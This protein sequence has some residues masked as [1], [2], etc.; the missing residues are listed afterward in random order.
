VYY[1]EDF[2][3]GDVHQGMVL[4]AGHM[5]QSTARL[6]W[7]IPERRSSYDQLSAAASHLELLPALGRAALVQKVRRSVKCVQLRPN[8]FPSWLVSGTIMRLTC[9][10]KKVNW[11]YYFRSRSVTGK[12]LPRIVE[13]RSP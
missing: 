11:T 10:H 7:K 5:A 8:R 13:G 3:E 2:D 4:S 9:L 1:S 12:P 6:R